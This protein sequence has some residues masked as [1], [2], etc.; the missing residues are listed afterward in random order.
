MQNISEIHQEPKIVTIKMEMIDRIKS[1]R[2]DPPSFS[3]LFIDFK[4]IMSYWGN[5]SPWKENMIVGKLYCN[6]KWFST[7]FENGKRNKCGTYVK[8]DGELCPFSCWFSSHT[9]IFHIFL[10]FD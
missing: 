8:K 9:L 2:I 5:T 1:N 4:D 6:T 7:F 3:W 10:C